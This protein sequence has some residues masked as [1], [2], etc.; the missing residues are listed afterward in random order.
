[1]HLLFEDAQKGVGLARKAGVLVD[2]VPAAAVHQLLQHPRRSPV[3]PCPSAKVPS[4]DW[5]V[6]F[7]DGKVH[8]YIGPGTRIAVLCT[9]VA[10][11]VSGRAST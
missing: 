3:Q 7:G 4:D 11:R 6:V 5:T 2:D 9:F 10:Q 1:M 8:T